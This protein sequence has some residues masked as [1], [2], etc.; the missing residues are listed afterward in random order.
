MRS[1]EALTKEVTPPVFFEN[2]EGARQPVRLDFS[3]PRRKLR[4]AVLA[5]LALF[6]P[7]IVALFLNGFDFQR[8]T[9]GGSAVWFCIM[10]P[11]VPVYILKFDVIERYDRP[12]IYIRSP[13]GKEKRWRPKRDKSGITAKDVLRV[14]FVPPLSLAIWFGIAC[15]CAMCYLTAFGFGD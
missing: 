6:L 13:E 1:P 12:W 5:I 9:L 14:L 4:T 15:F 10:V 7:V 2:L 11:V 3:S 8:L